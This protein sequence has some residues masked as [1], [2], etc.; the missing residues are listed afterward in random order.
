MHILSRGVIRSFVAQHR[1]LVSDRA[2]LHVLTYSVLR[3]FSSQLYQ[4]CVLIPRT[5]KQIR[6]TRLAILCNLRWD[7]PLNYFLGQSYGNFS[8]Q[9]RAMLLL[10]TLAFKI[11]LCSKVTG[12][13]RGC[14]PKSANVA[15]VELEQL[16]VGEARPRLR[17]AWVSVS[18]A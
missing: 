7:Q 5:S 8:P 6:T 15:Q 1:N 12:C 10:E 13:W 16:E 9:I 11:W 14:S 18:K 17:L 2:A 3:L 4:N